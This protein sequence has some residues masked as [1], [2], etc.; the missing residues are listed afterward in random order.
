MR[1]RTRQPALLVAGIA[2]FISLAPAYGGQVRVSM[3]IGEVKQLGPAHPGEP[4]SLVVGVRNTGQAECAPCQVRVLGGGVAARQPLPRIA[5]GESAR[6]TVGDLVFSRA[7]K[8]LLSVSV[9]APQDLVEF[10]GIRP[11]AAFE[12]T[13]LEGASVKRGSPR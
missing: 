13:V 1:R 8:Y 9:D 12:L 4:V 10:A 11:H 7:G 5:P 6:V 3:R 2:M